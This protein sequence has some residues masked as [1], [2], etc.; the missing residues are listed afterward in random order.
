[1][2][3]SAHM[4]GGSGGG[5]FLTCPSICAC[6]Y[7]GV[8]AEAF[9]DWF[10]VEFSSLHFANAFEHTGFV[11]LPLSACNSTAMYTNGL[12]VKSKLTMHI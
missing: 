8:P 3:A 2:S 6:I 12:D 11:G 10:S 7:T 5:M 9:S 4:K 1:M